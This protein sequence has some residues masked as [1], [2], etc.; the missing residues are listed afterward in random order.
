MPRVSKAVQ[1]LTTRTAQ[2]R[3]KKMTLQNEKLQMQVRQ[4]RGELAPVQDLKSE[5]IKANHVVKNKLLGL[6]SRLA[7]RLSG[8]TEPGEIQQT[9]RHEI[10]EALSELAYGFGAGPDRDAGEEK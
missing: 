1:A 2:Q 9:L 7:P 5:V 4:L 8:M 10:E 6:P 3:L